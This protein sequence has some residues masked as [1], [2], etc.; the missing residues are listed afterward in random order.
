MKVHVENPRFQGETI[1]EVLNF[2]LGSVLSVVRPKKQLV[3][4]I[5]WIEIPN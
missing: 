5:T 3:F 2:E 1:G 4:R